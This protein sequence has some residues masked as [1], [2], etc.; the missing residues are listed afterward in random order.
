MANSLHFQLNRS[1]GGE[2]LRRLARLIR[3]RG[4]IEFWVREKYDCAPEIIASY[5]M[6]KAVLK[7]HHPCFFDFFDSNH[8]DDGFRLH[9]GL[10]Y[11]WGFG[12]IVFGPPGGCDVCRQTDIDHNSKPAL[13]SS[14]GKHG[15][16]NRTSDNEFDVK[17]KWACL[18][19][20][21]QPGDV[22]EKQRWVESP[23][24]CGGSPLKPEAVTSGFSY[25]CLG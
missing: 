21:K 24:A 1:L 11:L 17:A 7:M 9:G 18:R 4:N 8:A 10:F 19:S 12:D 2:I 25:I 20:C 15:K 5:T 3:K 23:D 22:L 14:A 6:P 16:Q 13:S